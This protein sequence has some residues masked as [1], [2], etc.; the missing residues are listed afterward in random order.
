MGNGIRSS[1]SIS[2]PVVAGLILAA[3]AATLALT[4][5][6]R[7]R[8]HASLRA[9]F[10][11][12]FIG[13]AGAELALLPALLVA[14]FA[15]MLGLRPGDWNGWLLAAA[16]AGLT[17]YVVARLFPWREI[18]AMAADPDARLADVLRRLRDGG[19]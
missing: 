4:V 1:G 13:L 10:V 9:K 15:E 11:A 6:F 19:G 2:T 14:V 18:N 7:R 16:Y 3:A 17:A 12:V 5:Y 8:G